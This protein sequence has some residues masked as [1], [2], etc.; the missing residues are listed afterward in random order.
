VVFY[1]QIKIRISLQIQELFQV[2]KNA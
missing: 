2:E 1:H